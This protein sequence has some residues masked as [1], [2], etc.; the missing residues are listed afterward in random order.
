MN[1]TVLLIVIPLLLSFLTMLFKSLKKPLLYWGAIINVGLLFFLEKGE[2]MIGGFSAPYGISLILDQWSFIAV[3]LIN[4]LFLFA[5]VSNSNNLGNHAQI[6]LTLLA[7]VNGMVLTGDL[8]NLFV[9][10][11]ITTISAYIMTIQSKKYIHTFNYL[12]VGSIGSGLYL[13]GVIILYAS[14]GSLNL[15]N[16]T[17][18]ISSNSNALLLPFLL[19]FVGLS[20]ETKLFP[21][22]GW[23]KGIYNNA[24]GLVGSL[25]ASIVA[26][27]GLFVMG[28][29]IL[30]LF[31]TSTLVSNFILVIAIVT[32]ISGEFSAFKGTN[33]KEILLYSSIGQSGLV[34]LL[35]VTGLTFPALLV[36][37][38]N[39]VSKLIMFSVAD[40]LNP[41]N[42][43][44]HKIKGL[45]SEHK[46]IGFAFT[47]ASFSLIGLPLFLGFYAK[48]NSL[49]GLF[50]VHLIL[51]AVLLLITVVEGAYLMRLN[52]SL[53]HPGE[54]G[55]GNYGLSPSNKNSVPEVAVSSGMLVSVLVL[56]LVILIGGIKPELI[57]RQII[58]DYSENN[59]FSVYLID[60]KGGNE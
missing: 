54:E 51:P 21:F 29:I 33:I 47:I 34:T 40:V 41:E 36:I 12:I 55:Q 38:N 43:D 26:S 16:I 1:Y 39:A 4:T 59:N 25:M 44:T 53:W 7:G 49:I 2:Y 52:I 56:T 58:N 35:L 8:F 45:F 60:M 19:I 22:N 14:F 48:L 57:G 13:L 5:L 15:Q 3:V 17:N 9:F 37:V 32:L 11:E 23:V 18:L 27:A 28:R 30:S 42:H 46:M 31:T 24:N 10:M 50:D 20:V 6:M